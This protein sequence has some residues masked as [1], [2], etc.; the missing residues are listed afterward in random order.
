MALSVLQLVGSPESDFHVELSLLYARGCA[1][2]LSGRHQLCTAYVTPDGLWRFPIDLDDASLAAADPVPLAEAIEYLSALH[3]DVALPQMFC[4][5]GMTAY[6]ALLDI[7]GI[8]YLGNPPDVM[9]NSADKACARALV[10]ASGVAVPPGQVVTC[11]QQVTLPMP[12]VVKPAH[13]DNSH[14]IR[15]VRRRTALA[16]AI[17]EAATFSRDVLVE[18]YIEPGREVRCGVVQYGEEL[19]CLPLRNTRSTRP[20]RQSDVSQTSS[21]APIT[22]S[23]SWPPNTA[24]GPGSWLPMIPS[25][26]PYGVPPDVASGRCTVGTT[27]CS[28]SA[29]TRRAASGSSNRAPTVRSR[30]PV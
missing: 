30:H 8:P 1:D 15:L 21:R 7:I 17:A 6:R 18:T 27:V 5:T 16:A 4:R 3:V 14:G 26:T 20:S 22:A 19:L 24:I 28:T 11:A 12:V 13:A 2:A 10:S 23:C 9:A 29:S 25:P